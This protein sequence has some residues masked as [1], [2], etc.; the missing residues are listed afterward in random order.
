[1]ATSDENIKKI[2][3]NRL[4]KAKYEELKGEGS[5]NANEFYITP[6][7]SVTQEDLA[8]ALANKA[9][10][11]ETLAGYGIT[12]AYTKGEVDQKIAEKDSLP[13]Q[14][15]NAGKFLSTNGSEASWAALPEASSEVKGIVELASAEEIGAGTSE[16]VVPTVKQMAGELAKKQATLT[17]D[18]I[19]TAES[20]NPV[21]SKGIKSAIDGA[22][23]ELQGKIDAKAD[24]ATSLAGYG[25]EDAYTKGEV[26]GKLDTK[27]DKADTLAGYGITDAYTKGEVDAKVTSVYRYKGSVANEEALPDSD[28]V[29]GDVY[30]VEDT[31]ANFA[32]DGTK[33]DNLGMSVDLTPYL[34][35][36]AADEKYATKVELGNKADKGT[37][38]ASY[39]I[40]DAYTKGEVDGKLGNKADTSALEAKADKATSLAGYGIED[41]YTKNDVDGKLATKADTSAIPTK[42]SQLT[43][44][45]KYVTEEALTAKD[46]ATNTALTEGLATKQD[47]LTFDETPTAESN[48]PVKSK[49]IKSAIDTAKSELQSA[50]DGKAN[51]ATTLAGY[52]IADAYTKTE[53]D[54]AIEDRVVAV[55]RTWTDE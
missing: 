24:K 15:G 48:N 29:I 21:K 2:V 54:T 10:K 17:F 28:Q 23:A 52:G 16:T 26:D 25:I 30:N 31:G 55:I 41:A 39:G 46:Y 37:T 18:E 36:E 53:V 9:D 5:L 51:K 47:T 1:M 43:N 38:L 6:D 33:W 27:A 32:W 14:D 12:D 49:G 13:E 45:S 34:T 50:I 35:K 7:E 3:F 40:T 4:S 8:S 44:D 42:V 20:N 19:P 22:K 11:A